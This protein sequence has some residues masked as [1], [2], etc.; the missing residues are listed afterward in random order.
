MAGT[1]KKGARLQHSGHSGTLN[2]AI[3]L[4]AQAAAPTA[5]VRP[6]PKSAGTPT[7]RLEQQRLEELKRN[8]QDEKLEALANKWICG[9]EKCWNSKNGDYCWKDHAGKHYPLSR[10]H[11]RQWGSLL[12]GP[13]GSDRFTDEEPPATVM[14]LIKQEEAKARRERRKRSKSPTS[15]AA[16]APAPS[17][18]PAAA[19]GSVMTYM[20][21]TMET[22][23]IETSPDWMLKKELVDR[24][25]AERKF[26]ELYASSSQIY[27]QCF[28]MPVPS[29]PAPPDLSR[30]SPVDEPDLRA[31]IDWMK[32]RKPGHAAEFEKAYEKLFEACYSTE[33]IQRWKAGN[34]SKWAQLGIKEGLGEQLA[35]NVKT[36]AKQLKKTRQT[37][38]HRPPPTEPRKAF[39]KSTKGLILRSTEQGDEND[40]VIDVDEEEEQARFEREFTEDFDELESGAQNQPPA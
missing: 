26:A 9:E 20:R 6:A 33:Q 15:I 23:T 16:A 18:A 19:P 31:F 7:A 28:G 39:R 34:T 3:H 4:V 13:G 38:P 24:A 17:P 29:V 35:D 1:R 25:E 30:S 14:K 37:S 10:G 32:T 40:E 5:V 27:Q 8:E 22:R 12:Y 21:N 36:W 11:I 2:I